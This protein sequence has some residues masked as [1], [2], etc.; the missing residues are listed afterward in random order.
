MV[1][2]KKEKTQPE[3]KLRYLIKILRATEGVLQASSGNEEHITFIQEL[4]NILNPYGSLDAKKFLDLLK[5]FLSTNVKKQTETTK[6]HEKAQIDVEHISFDELRGLFSR[7]VLSKRQLLII[8]EKRLGLSKGTLQ[9]MRKEDI[10]HR[11]E[12][13]IQ[14]IETLKAI[15][16]KAAQ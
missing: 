8:A 11:I 6:R 7:N 4:R 15:K 3:I 12:S 9:K 13:A 1:G 14:N 5:D 16:R 2:E 10:Q